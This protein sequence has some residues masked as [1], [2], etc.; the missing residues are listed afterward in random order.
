MHEDFTRRHDIRAGSNR[1]FGWVMAGALTVVALAPLRHGLPL[2]TW[3]L[4]AAAAV[5]VIS[6]LVPG[7]LGPFN[8]AWTRFGLLL[9]RVTSPVLLGAVYFL[10]VVPTGLV[11]RALGRDPLRRARD[12]QAASYWIE[13][14]T[15]P[16]PMTRQF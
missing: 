7:V 10:A 5:A 9:N 12:P 3:A 16:G 13:R 8:A 4:V 14:E 1:S 6:A 15:G 2:R 11:M